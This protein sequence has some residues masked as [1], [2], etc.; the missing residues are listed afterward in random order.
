MHG[1]LGL[2]YSSTFAYLNGTITTLEKRF[3]IPT[4]N[5]G[6]ILVGY[7]VIALFMAP[8]MSYYFA[9]KHRPRWVAF[10]VATFGISCLGNALLHYIYGPGENALRLTV[11]YGA[12]FDS[13]FSAVNYDRG[14]SETLCQLNCKY[15]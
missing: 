2:V 3:N 9:T 7:D 8:I 15:Y 13:N 12:Y 4:R 5:A 6:I 10:G 14:A 1:I 11:E